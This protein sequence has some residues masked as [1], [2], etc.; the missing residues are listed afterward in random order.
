MYLYMHV[1]IYIFMYRDTYMYTAPGVFNLQ[2][3]IFN[4]LSPIYPYPCTHTYTCTYTHSVGK[5]GAEGEGGGREKGEGSIGM[6]MVMGMGT[7]MSND[8]GLFEDLW[9]NSWGIFNLQSS[10]HQT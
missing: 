1:V 2:S 5:C 7:S 10:N 6:G 8:Q 3:L 9:E 4:I